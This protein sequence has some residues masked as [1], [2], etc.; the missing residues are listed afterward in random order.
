[1]ILENVIGL[2]IFL[3]AFGSGMYFAGKRSKD[4]YT[5][6]GDVRDNEDLND[7]R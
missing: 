2:V 3:A 6:S 1:M 4:S 5:A 7:Y